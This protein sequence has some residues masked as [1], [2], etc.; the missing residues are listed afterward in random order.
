MPGPGQTLPDSQASVVMREM[1]DRERDR[2]TEGLEMER[3]THPLG[4][5]GEAP[6]GGNLL[7]RLCPGEA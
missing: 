4:L 6:W 7:G 1:G 2:G 5:S 3:R